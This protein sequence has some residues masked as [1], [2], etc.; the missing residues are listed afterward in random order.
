MAN[1]HDPL[2]DALEINPLPVTIDHKPLAKKERVSSDD[3]FEEVRDNIKRLID[4]GEMSYTELVAIAQTSQHPRAFEVLSSMLNSMVAANKQLL[5]IEKTRL[6]ISE[7]KGDLNNDK[8]KSVQNNLFVGS[9][10][11]ILDILN[12]KD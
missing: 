4:L 9:T 2:S 5:D 8:P 1:N 12:K 6:E 11:E 10:S 7:K 3:T